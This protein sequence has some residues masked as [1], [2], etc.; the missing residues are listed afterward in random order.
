[1]EG[2]EGSWIVNLTDNAGRQNL[3]TGVV[4]FT[5]GKL[6]GHDDHFQYDGTYKQNGTTLEADLHVKQYAAIGHTPLIIVKGRNEYDIKVRG[7][8]Q[9]DTIRA[10]GF[11]K[12]GL[13][14]ES[15]RATLTRQPDLPVKP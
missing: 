4:T 11:K 3:G 12:G 9:G 5:D 10:Q 7:T 2:L 14:S 1:M 13:R 6:S 8:L 15:L